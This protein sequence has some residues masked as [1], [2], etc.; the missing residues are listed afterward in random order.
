M[1]QLLRL[2]PIQVVAVAFSLTQSKRPT[3]AM[4]ANHLL[5]GYLSNVNVNPSLELTEDTLISLVN[6]IVHN[7]VCI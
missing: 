1:C 7:K 6:Y 5:R 3:L 4:I 2:S